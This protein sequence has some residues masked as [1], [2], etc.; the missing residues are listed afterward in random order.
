VY[1]TYHRA[2]HLRHRET[3]EWQ[4]ADWTSI[5]ELT[6][7][8]SIPVFL[9]GDFYLPGSILEVAARHSKVAGVML[10]RPALMNPSIFRCKTTLNERTGDTNI[11]HINDSD[12]ANTTQ[13]SSPPSKAS[14]SGF[15]PLRS[16]VLEY[17]RLSLRYETPYQVSYA[18]C[19]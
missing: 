18:F 4:D 15:S 9:N 19:A 5:E 8:V 12:S 13:L 6:N 14:S 11:D 1:T 10:A 7:S 2:V 3:R 16:A 17:V